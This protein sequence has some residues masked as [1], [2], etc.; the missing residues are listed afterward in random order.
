MELLGNFDIEDDIFFESEKLSSEHFYFY[1]LLPK[2]VTLDEHGLKTPDYV[3]NV[4]HNIPLY[5]KMTDKYRDRL[6]SK[7]GWNIYP[8]KEADELTPEEIYEGINKF[9]EDP[10]GN[11]QIY[12]FRFPPTKD[13]GPNMEKILDTKK[14]IRIDLNDPKVKPYIHNIFWGYDGSYTGNKKLDRSFYENISQK[15]YFSKYDD[16]S[17]MSFAPLNHISIDPENGYLPLDIL[18]VFDQSENNI[19]KESV[20]MKKGFFFEMDVDDDNPTGEGSLDFDFDPDDQSI[21]DVPMSTEEDTSTN[22]SESVDVTSKLPDSYK[23]WLDKQSDGESQPL[24]NIDG[25]KTAVKLFNN[26]D[27]Q[28]RFK[29]DC[30]IRGGYE[31]K[32]HF[33]EVFVAVGES[34][35][36]DSLIINTITGKVAVWEHETCDQIPVAES[37]DEFIGKIHESTD[38]EGT[39]EESNVDDETIQEGMFDAGFNNLRIKIANAI[40][41]KFK[42]SNVVRG[43][44]GK[45]M[46]TI[47]SKDD[48][49]ADTRTTVESTGTGCKVVTRG[50]GKIKC[51]FNNISLSSA[52]DKILSLFE[53]PEL[54]LEGALYDISRFGGSLFQEADEETNNEDDI[55]VPKLDEPPTEED[56]T[57]SENNEKSDDSD[58]KEGNEDESAENK[59]PDGEDLSSFGTDTSTEQNEYDPEE[60]KILNEMIG[61]EQFA[62]T[63]YFD[64]AKNTNVEVLRRLYSDI[65]AE[66]SFHSEQL[67]YAKSTI[68]G[69]TY[70]PRNENV[71]KEYEELLAMGMDE[72]TA[73]ST[74]IDKAGMIGGGVDDGDDSDMEKIEQEA[75]FIAETLYH[76]E[77]LSSICEQYVSSPINRD[78]ALGVFVEAYFMEAIDNVASAPKEVTKIHSPIYVLKK[79]LKAAINGLIKLSDVARDSIRRSKVKNHRKKQWLQNHGIGDLF[80]SGIHLYLYDDNANKMDFDT[81]ARY[82]DF[83]YR[84]TK[85]IGES[86]GIK[87]TKDAQHKTIS[88]PIQFKNVKEGMYKLSQVVFNKTKV[89]VTD[90]NKEV[91][92]KEFFGYSDEKINVSVT[93]G[94]GQAVNDSN[95][96]YNKLDALILVTK[97]Y[98]EISEAV[99]DELL[100]L[101]GDVNSIY[102]KNRPAY[103]SAKDNMSAIVKKYNQFI[104]AMGHDLSTII[105]LDNGLLKMTRERDISEQNGG[106]WDGPDVR[107]NPKAP[108]QGTQYTKKRK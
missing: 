3:Y 46:F 56:S 86:C 102:Y 101:E 57:N 85:A 42:V 60:I 92:T 39:Q 58:S 18:D 12:M 63:R 77:L 62:M 41:D 14:I 13:L 61:D 44:T 82:V 68:T 38:D 27:V 53:K 16:N 52:L 67:L 65:G 1:H 28:E 73:V 66:E 104:S 47:M 107:V 76:N 19:V 105:K 95:N 40:G 80:K 71:K 90:K 15:D 37:W 98:A 69:E 21:D 30:E 48:S 9:R 97:K 33:P 94:T 49:S 108:Q 31:G 8:G 78:K 32:N 75:A 50:E 89:V 79:G 29:Q 17:K 35:F 34:P 70:R 87:L 59:T 6:V 96:I 24:Y 74:A 11:N 84:L 83:L 43:M 99:L 100:K 5:L 20:E 55:D 103:N 22:E 45:D 51:N 106:S 93:H 36:G 54:L 23:T 81:P 91:L 64:A 25:F 26:N 7:N 4:E 10:R 88:N 2:D 72:E